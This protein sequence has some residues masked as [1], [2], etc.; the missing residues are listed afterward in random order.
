M[1]WPTERVLVHRYGICC[2]D[3][4][5]DG[6]VDRWWWW[7]DGTGASWGLSEDDLLFSKGIST[8]LI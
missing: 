5:L 7:E 3:R 2:I 4:F 8:V 1:S 6:R